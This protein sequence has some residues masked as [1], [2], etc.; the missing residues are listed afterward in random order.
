MGF[1]IYYLF[2]SLIF[3]RFVVQQDLDIL[4]LKTTGGLLRGRSRVNWV[5]LASFNYLR[6]VHFRLTALTELCLGLVNLLVGVPILIRIW[7]V[8]QEGCHFSLKLHCFNERETFENGDTLNWILFRF[9]SL[10]IAFSSHVNHWKLTLKLLA[11]LMDSVC[12]WNYYPAACVRIFL[13]RQHVP[14]HMLNFHFGFLY[15]QDLLHVDLSRH[16]AFHGEIL[17]SD[18]SHCLDRLLLGH[19]PAPKHILVVVHN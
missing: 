10:L 8:L 5:G 14:L 12:F 17:I 9:I 1:F 15:E 11:C 2:L 19:A 16:R 7:Q 13:S 4:A 18:L 3:N 6:L